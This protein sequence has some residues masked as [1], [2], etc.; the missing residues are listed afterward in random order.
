M[1]IY[2]TFVDILGS[3]G[4]NNSIRRLNY[5]LRVSKPV[6]RTV[7]FLLIGR[8]D[9]ISGMKSFCARFDSAIYRFLSFFLYKSG[10]FFKILN[11][12][13]HTPVL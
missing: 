8:I 10:M 2:A 9:L 3:G 11:F 6:L 5:L 1:N 13:F 12:I 7:L 4:Q